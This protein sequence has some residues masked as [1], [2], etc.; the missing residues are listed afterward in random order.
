M[1]ETIKIDNY[2]NFSAIEIGD[3]SRVN[4]FVGRNNSGKSCLLEAVWPK[5]T[6]CSY[7]LPPTTPIPSKESMKVWLRVT[8]INHRSLST[9]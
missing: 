1:F 6:M 2:R 3:L 8:Y 7:S 9:S 5:P 4:L